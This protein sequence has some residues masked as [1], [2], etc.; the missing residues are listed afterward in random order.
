[1]PLIDYSMR[2]VVGSVIGTLESLAAEKNLALN[3]SL[4]PDLP[5]GRGNEQRI[6]QVLLNLVGNAIKFTDEGEISVE[7]TVSD[8]NFVVSVSDTGIGISEADQ[9]RI[10]EKFHR[11]DNAAK[12]GNG[13][14]G[15]GLAIAKRMIEM[16]R[17][18]MWVQS[19]PGKG[20]IFSFSL[21]IV[22]EPQPEAV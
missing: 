20:S 19:T 3:V 18:R 1:M 21:P 10:F 17:G 22:V 7:V 13:G 8:D 2:D 5:F 16:Q 4:P 12:R 9:A 15:L 6:T 14:T 11:V